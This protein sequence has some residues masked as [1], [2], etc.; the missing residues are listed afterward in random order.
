MCIIWKKKKLKSVVFMI[1]KGKIALVTFRFLW[2]C[3]FILSFCAVLPFASLRMKLTFV[4]GE[5]KVYC[6]FKRAVVT[7]FKA[8]VPAK[9][10]F[11]HFALHCSMCV[12]VDV[13]KQD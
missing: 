10:V 1:L 7:L 11:L 2:N 3:E 5:N 8:F 9:V 6:L 13:Y 12:G 4:F